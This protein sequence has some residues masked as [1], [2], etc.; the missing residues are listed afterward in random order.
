MKLSILDMGAQEYGDCLY[1]EKGGVKVLI[2]GG[3]QGDFDGQPGTKSLPAQLAQ[4]SKTA[5]SK[6]IEVDLLV[7]THSHADH[8]GCLPKMV[9][10]GKLRA[11]FALLSDPNHRWGAP[12]TTPTDAPPALEKAID[13]LGEEVPPINRFKSTEDLR[14]FLDAAATLQ[15]Q[16]RDM[17][18]AL[19]A[20]TPKT[21]VVRYGTDA[22]PK[23]LKTVLTK[24]GLTILGPTKAH[25][26]VCADRLE[27]QRDNARDAIMQDSAA[28]EDARNDYVELYA[29]LAGGGV[30]TDALFDV[31]AA[32]KFKGAIND[33]SIVF[34][35]ELGSSK[36]LLSGDMQL[37]EAQTTGLEAIMATLVT[38]IAGAG[39]YQAVKLPHHTS[40][41]G[42]NEDLHNTHLSAPLLIHSGGR[43]DPDHP[44]PKT[45]KMLKQ[46]AA[47]HTFIRNDRNGLIEIE[48]DGAKLKFKLAKPGTN[49]FT[50]NLGSDVGPLKTETQTAAVTSSAL[51]QPAG[52]FVRV[53]ADIPNRRTRVTITVDIDPS[54]SGPVSQVSQSEKKK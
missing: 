1:I 24:A 34:R 45:L 11:R 49:D 15:K 21:V 3:H 46:N 5:A 51:A 4:V 29:R 47:G 18:D 25:L 9:K 53:H 35:L 50:P 44:E 36:I 20:T 42:W 26:K 40:Y 10:T 32:S 14:D 19:K 16:Y 27:E 30:L 38:K 43:D 22:I 33:L 39:P 13:L 31:D 28:L 23:A 2:D 52:D 17:I 8:I 6:P 7:V 37:A 41:N 48:P 12:S 54:A